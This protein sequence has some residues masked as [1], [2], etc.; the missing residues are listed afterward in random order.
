MG[1]PKGSAAALVVYLV[2]EIVMLGFI[3]C[4]I[5]FERGGLVSAVGPP[6]TSSWELEAGELG[7]FDR[8][9]WDGQ[10]RGRHLGW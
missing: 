2:L 4:V 1:E 8:A 10:S 7:V 3:V 5:I 6:D 9:M